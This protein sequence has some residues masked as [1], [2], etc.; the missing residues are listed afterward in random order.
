VI[1]HRLLPS[2]LAFHFLAQCVQCIF[3]LLKYR[4]PSIAKST[5]PSN[6]RYS[7]ITLLCDSWAE[8]D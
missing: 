7:F 5:T 2:F 8:M 1:I 4:T 3:P 6:T